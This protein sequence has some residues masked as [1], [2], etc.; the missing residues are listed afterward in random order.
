MSGL[1]IDELRMRAATCAS[2]ATR[3]DAS[4]DADIAATKYEEAAHALER[5]ADETVGLSEA[6]RGV[7]LHKVAEYRKRAEQL[8]SLLLIT[9]LPDVGG[10]APARP[11]DAPAHPPR[12]PAH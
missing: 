11:E 10:G 4:G 9:S 5:L 12:P 7:A 2:D 6:D 1:S 8:R 3:A